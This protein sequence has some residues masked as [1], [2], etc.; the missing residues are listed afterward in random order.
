MRTPHNLLQ[1]SENCE[2]CRLRQHGFFCE[3][4]RC[5]LK[6]FDRIK[7]LSAYSKGAV[8][9]VENEPP[10]GIFLL[11]QG[12]VKLSLSSADGKTLTLRIAKPGEILGLMAAI[13]GAPYEATA[14]TVKPSQVAFVRRDDFL[15]FTKEH[16]VVYEKVLHQIAASYAQAC[17]QLRSVGLFPVATRLARVLLEWSSVA[18]ETGSVS[19]S[20]PCVTVPLTHGE[21]GELIGTTRETVNR[22]LRD[23]TERRLITL[24]GPALTIHNRKALEKLAAA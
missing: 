15:K 17:E 20:G 3:V 11:C 2:S 8:L 16:P 1:V 18:A 13:T 24:D 14:R 9:F 22:T 5:S 7:H 10:R 19:P 4:D 21:I 23:F 6:N 12:E